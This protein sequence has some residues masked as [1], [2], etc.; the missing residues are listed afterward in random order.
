[1]KPFVLI[2]SENLA[3]VT[4]IQKYLDDFP[5]VGFWFRCFP[6]AIFLAS[7]IDA[8]Q[9]GHRISDRFF[10]DKG[11]FFISEIHEEEAWGILP[12]QAWKL[13]M[14]PE[15]PHVSDRDRVVGAYF[16]KRTK[17]GNGEIKFET[18]TGGKKFAVLIMEEQVLGRLEMNEENEEIVENLQKLTART[19]SLGSPE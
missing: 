10:R 12:M 6:N 19:K 13:I 18:N 11:R 16:L 3:T 4:E 5:E 9:L 8:N 2:F 7:S 14:D 15:N 17:G 1:M